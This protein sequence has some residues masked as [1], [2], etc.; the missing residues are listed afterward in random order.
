MAD[1]DTPAAHKASLQFERLVFFSDAVFAI[2]ITLLVLDLKLPPSATGLIDWS[3]IGPKLFG[4]GLSFAV[5]GLYWLDHH[6]LFGGLRR[7]D[8]QLRLANL[9]FLAS[10]IFL[11]FPT[12]VIAEYPASVDSVTF[13]AVSVAAVGVLTIILT[14]V[15][16][17]PALLTLDEAKRPIW[18]ILAPSIGAPVVFLIS[19]AVAQSQPRLAMRL[20]WLVAPAVW[21]G[22]WLGGAISRAASAKA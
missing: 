8:L 15:A 17:R 2:A 1:T 12:S 6:Q 16:R 9:V 10:V 3:L 4:F 14:L 21:G 18:A 11:P 13:Y 22:R 5:I 20:W 7:D 19:A